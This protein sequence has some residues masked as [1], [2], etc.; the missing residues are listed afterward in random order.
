MGQNAKKTK[1]V[2]PKNAKLKSQS[3]KKHSV[4]L[5]DSYINNIARFH[6]QQKI[7]NQL[8]SSYNRIAPSYYAKSKR[9]NLLTNQ[10]ETMRNTNPLD[11]KPME[12]RKMLSSN[13]R[14]IRS[15][16]FTSQMSG[17]YIDALVLVALNNEA[18]DVVDWYGGSPNAFDSEWEALDKQD[19]V[20]GEMLYDGMKELRLTRYQIDRALGKSNL[21]EH[22]KQDVK[23]SLLNYYKKLRK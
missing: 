1:I 19:E 16:G 20:F 8:E 14:A 3:L 21:P 13:T 4:G 10:F 7:M 12:L 11:L 18:Y 6:K 5:S 17:D 23:V 15:I 2:R 9:H 22:I